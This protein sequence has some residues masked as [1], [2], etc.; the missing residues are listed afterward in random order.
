MEIHGYILALC[1]LLESENRMLHSGEIRIGMLVKHSRYGT[2]EIKDVSD[3]S[4][5]VT[6]DDENWGTK[7]YLRK[8]AEAILSTLT[9]AELDQRIHHPRPAFPENDS[10]DIQDTEGYSPAVDEQMRSRSRAWV[11]RVMSGTDPNDPW[12]DPYRSQ[13]T[14][15]KSTMNPSGNHIKPFHSVDAFCDEFEDALQDEI[16]Y[17]KKNGGT[18]YQLMDGKLVNGTHY[19]YCYES[20]VELHI[21]YNSPVRIWISNNEWQPGTIVSCEEY[22]VVFHTSSGLGDNPQDVS[23][24]SA[25]WQ[26]IDNLKEHISAFRAGVTPIVKKLICDGFYQIDGGVPIT[27]GQ[28]K[29]KTMATKQDISFIWGPPGTGK[30]TTLVRIATDCMLHEKRVLMVSYSNVAVDDA[31][32]RFYIYFN[33]EYGSIP[34]TIL[35][36]GYPRNQEVI[37]H[38]ILSSFNMAIRSNPELFDEYNHLRR[39]TRNLKKDTKEYIRLQTRI[40]EIRSYFKEAEEQ[41][42]R[43]AGFVATTVAKAVSDPTIYCQTFDTVLFDEASMA[44]IPQVIFSARLAKNHFVCLGDFCQLPPIVQSGDDSSLNSDIFQYCGIQAAIEHK[45]SHKWLCL[46]DVQRRMHP[47]IADFINNGMYFGLLSSESELYGEEMRREIRDH[48]PAANYS[49]GMSDISSFNAHCHRT[50]DFSHYNIFSAMTSYANAI[51]SIAPSDEWTAGIITPYNA[52]ARLINAMI[53]DTWENSK[54]W[55]IH[56][57]TVHQFQGSEQ[58]IIIYDAVDSNPLQRPGGLLTKTKNNMANRLFNVAVS[59]AQGKFIMVV[60]RDYIT[61]RS[62]KGNNLFRKYAL[63]SG[64]SPKEMENEEALPYSL[65]EYS[66]IQVLKNDS[67]ERLIDGDICNAEREIVFDIADIALIRNS[68]VI[69]KTLQ[70][71]G[72]HLDGIDVRVRVLNHGSVKQL[73]EGPVIESKYISDNLLIIDKRVVW[74]FQALT[75]QNEGIAFGNKSD[76]TCIRFEGKYTGRMLYSLLKMSYGKVIDS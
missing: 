19:S 27:S 68:P 56:S 73:Y 46:L 53:H 23:I 43:H 64:V 49:L 30:T 34:G 16:D 60:D 36:Y 8:M 72:E 40:S 57:A 11:S 28:E 61:S 35:R 51:K 1:Y 39:R 45:W 3:S 55:R 66:R 59:R 5:T 18:K 32:L 41:L 25:P 74:Y 63:R 50:A 69:R 71:I 21:P 12:Y 31:A 7:K 17:V 75:S 9:E 2:G 52:Q 38:P 65:P 4:V 26:L 33:K 67:A 44:Y 37:D 15:Y 14:G 54:E 10:P 29:A 6:Y 20:E 62:I 76:I 48:E 22:T 58:N 24:S 42:V 70:K 47:D 13:V